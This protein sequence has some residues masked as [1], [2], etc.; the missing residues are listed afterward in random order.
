MCLLPAMMESFSDVEQAG[1]SRLLRSS[2]ANCTEPEDLCHGDLVIS[3][4][5][6]KD[7]VERPQNGFFSTLSTMRG[8]NDSRSSSW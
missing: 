5:E 8:M 3:L 4:S 6:G 2:R 7:T 1:K